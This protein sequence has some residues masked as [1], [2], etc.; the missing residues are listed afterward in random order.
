M[1]FFQRNLLLLTA[2]GL[3]PLLAA[4]ILL[5]LSIGLNNLGWNKMPTTDKHS[6]FT[7]Q[8]CGDDFVWL[9]PIYNDYHGRYEVT[10]AYVVG[11]SYCERQQPY[12]LNRPAFDPSYTVSY[13]AFPEHKKIYQSISDRR[14]LQPEEACGLLG[15]SASCLQCLKQHEAGLQTLAGS[16]QIFKKAELLAFS[17]ILV[18]P[19]FLLVLFA[20]AAALKKKISLTIGIAMLAIT[21]YAFVAS[22][23]VYELRNDL[24]GGLINALEWGARMFTSPQILVPSYWL[25]PIL[26]AYGLTGLFSI[27][28]KRNRYL[29]MTVIFVM[30]SLIP[31]GCYLYTPAGYLVHPLMLIY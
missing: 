6:C 20:I 4:G 15:D 1:S 24:G 30:F 8:Y 5:L 2:V 28:V 25:W 12:S 7:S 23:V 22:D 26:V 14:E 27:K 17:S 21:T 31:I 3:S 9:V 19:V 29:M 13:D 16:K 10:K 18:V 11:K